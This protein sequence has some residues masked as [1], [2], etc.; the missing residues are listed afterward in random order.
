MADQVLG[1]QALHDDDDG[2]AALVVEAGVERVV[3]EIV[4]LLPL[5]P[6]ADV[7]GLDRVVDDDEVGAGAED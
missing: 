3:E 1:V 5:H 2:A 4:D 6:R 7:L